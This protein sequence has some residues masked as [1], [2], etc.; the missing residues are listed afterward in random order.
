[1][2]NTWKRLA[3]L[4]LCVCMLIGMPISVQANAGTNTPLTMTRVDVVNDT[5][6][7]ITFSE[8]VNLP[9]GRFF[10][11]IGIYNGTG[12]GMWRY[13]WDAAKNQPASVAASGSIGNG[14]NYTQWELRNIAYYQGNENQYVA[15]IRNFS[16]SKIGQVWDAIK[17][18]QA[19]A[20]IRLVVKFDDN[21]N[22]DNTFGD[23]INAVTSKIGGK[24]LQRT[25]APS[26]KLDWSEYKLG[27]GLRLTGAE[28]Y[29]STHVGMIFSENVAVPVGCEITLGLYKDGVLDTTKGGPWTIKD[30]DY[31]AIPRNFNDTAENAHNVLLGRIDGATGKEIKDLAGTEYKIGLT[32]TQ[33]L[34]DQDILINGLTNPTKTKSLQATTSMGQDVAYTEVAAKAETLF[35]L[36]D[37]TVINDKQAVL[38]FSE[39]VTMTVKNSDQTAQCYAGLYLLYDSR[40]TVYTWDGSAYKI[41]N[42]NNATKT[43]SPSNSQ[44][45]QFMGKVTTDAAYG[46]NQLLFTFYGGKLNGTNIP[47][48]FTEIEKVVDAAKATGKLTRMVFRLGDPAPNATVTV[49]NNNRV[50]S[51]TSANGTTLYAQTKFNEDMA[52]VNF[53]HTVSL[54]G[55]QKYDRDH[56]LLTFDQPIMKSFDGVT[57]TLGLYKNGVQDTEKGTWT[58]DLSTAVAIDGNKLLC[59]LP[60]GLTEAANGYTVGLVVESETNDNDGIVEGITGANGQPLAANGTAVGSTKSDIAYV[61]VDMANSLIQK[62][63]YV[64]S[65]EVVAEDK[66]KV[67]FTSPIKNVDVGAG[68]GDVLLR[69][70]SLSNG[71]YHWG[72]INGE[73]PQWGG[74]VNFTPADANRE[75]NDVWYYTYANLKA[76]YM[77]VNDPNSQYSDYVLTLGL[78]ELTPQSNNDGYVQN[79][80]DE[81]GNRLVA[82]NTARNGSYTAITDP[83][84]IFGAVVPTRAESI[85]MTSEDL[86]TVTF[87]QPVSSAGIN[88]MRL[89]FLDANGAL[90]YYNNGNFN[91][92]KSGKLLEF[93][94]IG[95]KTDDEGKAWALVLDLP[96]SAS[97]LDLRTV[98]ALRELADEKGYQLKLAYST[99]SG[100]RM[101]Y[102]DITYTYNTDTSLGDFKVEKVKQINNHELL[103]TF[104][105]DLADLVDMNGAA[106]PFIS[107]RLVDP[108]TG[109][110]V[111]YHVG[112]NIPLTWNPAGAKIE[113]YMQWPAKSVTINGENRNQLLVTFS[114]SLDIGNLIRQTN[115]PED[116]KVYDVAFSFEEANPGNG[117][118]TAGNG[119][120]HHVRRAADGKQMN[121]MFKKNVTSSESFLF[122][123]KE[124]DLLDPMAE[125]YVDSIK[126]IDQTRIVVT[127]SESVR[128]DGGRGVVGLVNTQLQTMR[129]ANGVSYEWGGRLE[130]YDDAHTQLVFILD[131]NGRN[132]RYPMQGLDDIVNAKLESGDYKLM[133]GVRDS[134]GADGC[135]NAITTPTGKVLLADMMGNSVDTVWCLIDKNQIPQG[136]L[137]LNK[138]EIISDNAA[139]AT[140]S[141]PI[142]ITSDPFMCIR[143]FNKDGNMVWLTAEGEYAFSSKTD[144]K[145]NTPM[146][147][148]CK[149]EWYDKA[150]TQIKIIIG[151]GRE[152]QANF[153]EIMNYDFNAEV[154]GSYL[155]FG[156]E[157]LAPGAV[158]ANWRVDNV[159]LL[160]DPRIAL[161]ATR[162]AGTSYDGTYIKDFVCS[163]KPREV[164]VTSVKLLNDMQIRVTFSEPVDMVGNVFSSIRFIDK[165]TGGLLYW[166]DEY[167]RN[168]VQFSGSL[169]FENDS[170]TSMIWT[171]KGNNAFGA[172]NIYD[173][174]N[175]QN[176]L[177]RLKGAPMQFCI[178]ELTVADVITV[179]GRNG[180]IDNLVAKDGVN[181]VKATKISGYDSIWYD[182]D[183]T[184]LKGK[185]QLELL[186]VKAI[187]D[188]TLEITFSESVV[189]DDADEHLS[190][191]IRYLTLTGDSEFLANGKTAK[192]NGTWEYKDENKNV[193]IWKLNSNNADNLTEI[194]N[195]EG[196]LKWNRGARVCFVLTNDNKD[197]PAKTM[198]VKGITD[199]SGYRHLTCKMMDIATA[200]ID[201]EI[202]YD[203]PDPI[204]ES[205]TKDEELIEYYSNYVSP[206]IGGAAVLV[207][208]AVASVLIGRRKKEGK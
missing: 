165:E 175:Y 88:T 14:V 63:L 158:N 186:S 99:V 46:N 189:I 147:W 47:F 148:A 8:A 167:N 163:F 68:T 113:R 188:Q 11:G 9:S 30:V 184:K 90:V 38:T 75:Y 44:H 131:S 10:A 198:R 23:G 197:L 18:S 181:H 49:R 208:G 77:A 66:I 164:K 170:H 52:E 140:F 72:S 65:A 102:Q 78:Q 160:S 118:Y 124:E 206:I 7:V 21:N 183:L 171:I 104:S 16:A 54:I 12:R 25:E 185:D 27:T 60:A 79:F 142:E 173:I 117:T 95:T 4:M 168:P 74:K 107:L 82:T 50:E 159:R 81:Q 17:A 69:L 106:K 191:S 123:I 201:I 89:R 141:A 204:V 24:K 199:L 193:I 86:I 126:V 127:F 132:N 135:V 40:V 172:C 162:T 122:F 39:P 121:G 134:S 180:L 22:T 177:S 182:F 59:K 87:D 67:K 196:T 42:I 151:G 37:V 1:M 200:Q 83:N 195:F 202:A 84:G 138:I 190:M 2:R 115:M 71:E 139:I 28:L 137:T 85:K 194:F 105:H 6:I 146:Q 136:K 58:V 108:A 101:Y 97:G 13:S 109:S 179:G 15:D 53:T 125:I 155:G 153:V 154:E 91:T 119:L 5:K 35:T 207:A 143:W 152:G 203:K 111:R 48:G 56:I 62:V 120:V 192:F 166:G 32:V 80:V 93:P 176:A 41:L 205:D 187:D 31:A 45:A 178:E 73:H 94:L 116:L 98:Q 150:H 20:D 92:N 144:G 110:I 70:V 169:A 100:F 26:D 145:S 96:N 128:L 61:T 57:A 43:T 33:P 130:Y 34:A 112:S 51:F 129:D 161:T 55:A 174:V 19:N 103:V 133:F 3:S 156:M 149:W 36:D 157:E 64:E 76:I 114:D 29:D